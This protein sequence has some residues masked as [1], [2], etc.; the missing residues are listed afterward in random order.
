MQQ[1]F[2]EIFFCPEDTQGAKGPHGPWWVGDPTGSFLA[3]LHLYKYSKIPKTL[4]ESMKH[5]SS[6]CK[7]QNHE[8]QSRALFRHLARG[9]HD[10]GGVHHPHSD[11]AWVINHR[12]KGLYAVARW[13][14]LS[15]WLPI[16][17][18]D[19]CSCRSISCNDFLWCVCW[20]PMNFEFMIRSM[21]LSMKVIW[22]FFDH[23]YAWLTNSI[24]FLSDILVLFGQLDLFILQWEVVLRDGFDLMVLDPSDRRGSD[25]YVSLL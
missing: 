5:V 17:C 8:I 22:V 21:F 3:C 14:L 13:L 23:L 2:L 11:D 1:N 19:R 10:R 15:F 24:Y 18:S 4:G 7:F 12:P 6:R 9:E 25:T 20:D 16:Q